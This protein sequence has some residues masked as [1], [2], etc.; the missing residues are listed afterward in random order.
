MKNSETIVPPQKANGENIRVLIVEDSATQAAQLKY[1]LEEEGYTVAT[2]SN[3]KEALTV[4]RQG[5]PSLVIS[6]IVMP[7]MDGYTLCHQIK[8]DATLK[9]IPV[10]LLTSLTGAEEVLKA[11][12]CGADNFAR[13][14]YDGK[15]LLSLVGSIL[16]NRETRKT[17]KMQLGLEID[18]AGEKHFIT[19]ERQQILDLLLST[20]M[21]AVQLN[22]DLQARE[23]QLARSYQT[24]R[25]LY[26]IADAL[27]R[28]TS[29]QEA[30]H[31]A[32]RQAMNL[33]G[34]QAGWVSLREGETGFRLA[35]ACG[36]PPALETPGALEGDCLC[37]RKLLAGELDRA[38]NILECE[39]LQQAKGDTHGLRCHSSIALW[40]GNRAVGVMNLVGP[41]QGQFSTESLEIFYS[42]GNQVAVA[43]ERAYLLQK[44]EEKVEERTTALT[45]EI[46]ERKQLETQLY[47]AQKMEAIGRLAGGIAHDFNNH[48][49]IIIGYSERMLDR[50]GS[51]D[52]LRKSAGLIKDAALRSASLTRQLL[53]FSRRQ[54]F[55]PT[56]LDL[57]AAITEL[58][59]M[60]RPLI[61]EDIE[62]VTSLDPALGK[63]RADPAQM[64][65][66]IMNLA[67]NSRDAMPQGGRLTIESANVELDESYARA[68]ATVLPGPYV[69]LA[70]TDTG[71]GMDKKTQSHMF[72]PFF[73]TK[74][75]D[76]GTGLGLATVYGI[77]KQSGGY[78][79][80]YS[81]PGRGTTFKIYLP[82]LEAGIQEA[83][84]EKA[85]PP[86]LKGEETILIV[87]DEGM[88]RE[89]AC[90]FLQESGYKVLDAA[91]GTEA[92]EVSK[93]HQAPIQLLM[94][95]AVMPGMTGR[96]LAQ[97]LRQVRPETKVLYV[98]GYTDDS[99]L[100]NGLLESG[101]AF[102]QKPF[103]RDALARKVREVLEG[104]KGG[105]L[106]TA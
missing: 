85:P 14:P 25:G 76:K 87:E 78:I 7:E 6:D 8:S 10:L 28:A 46:A 11:L 55:E 48:L 18:I 12:Q 86:L 4:T 103:T 19:S 64:D 68:H 26:G 83:R 43:L 70:V 23:N 3:G 52:P 94:T 90:L 88:L 95:D 91:N 58:G 1:L 69:M 60:L 97:K 35:A 47:Q 38:T 82:R 51:E 45:A 102:L 34:V 79:W 39:R 89:L 77:V 84:V 59:K 40:I 24:L 50:L 99:V 98:S 17:A 105:P 101:T 65:Q 5:K 9:D 57:N 41:G 92:M 16:A 13:K 106:P 63:V 61:G 104:G 80:V 2:A 66:V 44:M 22:R 42:L 73:T 27:N 36:L 33:P 100:R 67:V 62:L 81:E 49:G 20:F 96:E 93:R 21:E 31:E 71:T 29:E 54:V 15:R 53:A 75:K 72:E 30:L 74:E 32:L 56:I 37:R